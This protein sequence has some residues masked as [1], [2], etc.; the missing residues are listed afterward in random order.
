MAG[1]LFRRKDTPEAAPQGAAESVPLPTYLAESPFQEMPEGAGALDL[2]PPTVLSADPQD[3]ESF[4]PPSVEEPQAA[5]ARHAAP[6]SAP[7]E[8]VTPSGAAVGLMDGLDDLPTVSPNAL[9]SDQVGSVRFRVSTPQGYL[10]T[11]VE[12]FVN[13]ARESL[14]QHEQ[15]EFQLRRR[16]VDVTN[17]LRLQVADSASLRRQIEVFRVQGD[18]LVD[19]DG[20]YVT[21][22]QLGHEPAHAVAEMEALRAELAAVTEERDALAAQMAL[23]E[24]PDTMVAASLGELPDEDLV[25][26]YRELSTWAQQAEEELARLGQDKE[27]SDAELARLRDELAGAETA[28]RLAQESGQEVSTEEVAALTALLEAEQSKNAEQADV[29]ERMRTEIAD[30]TTEL[31]VAH[32]QARQARGERDEANARVQEMEASLTDLTEGSEQVASTLATLE[33]ERDAAL[34]ERDTA[35]EEAEAAVRERDRLD[36][37]LQSR[38]AEVQSLREQLAE[39]STTETLAP[40]STQAHQRELEA[41][42]AAAKATTDLADARTD[43]ALQRATLAE[44]R[45]ERLTERISELRDAHAGIEVELSEVRTELAERATELAQT[46]RKLIQAEAQILSLEDALDSGQPSSPVKATTQV[47]VPNPPVPSAMEALDQVVAEQAPAAGIQP[48][49]GVPLAHWA[50]ELSAPIPSEDE[51]E[52]GPSDEPKP[53]STSMPAARAQ[54]RRRPGPESF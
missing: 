2:T 8:P 7:E 9:T 3:S 1:G 6:P 33:T 11:Q 16:I 29:L 35:V 49:A 32:E 5:P 48:P 26:A 45:V 34:A 18:P 4:L 21:E 50:P 23:G 22:S 53:T 14:Q 47:K 28:L 10:F 46:Q 39:T 54:L 12:A 25:V 20:A 19:S 41:V 13:A 42:R 17:E 52:D 31:S 15:V 27:A 37:V 38:D 40:A 51:D 24:N 36:V 43:A 44:K 30:A